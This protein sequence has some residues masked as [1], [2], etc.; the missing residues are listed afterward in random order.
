MDTAQ[1]IVFVSN[2]PLLFLALAAVVGWLL[3]GEISRRTRG[4][5][6]ISP[7]EATSLINHEGAFLLDIREDNEYRG[8]HIVNS[9][10]IPQKQIQDRAKELDKHKGRPVITY[11][12]TGQRSAQVGKVLQ[13]HGF[14][15]VYNLSGGITA[16][17]NANL[18]T[19]RN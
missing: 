19:S 15:S 9:V 8:G 1:F 18:P 14:E 17:Q 16:W 7:L 3:V 12:R 2:H 5:K 4:F 13:Q 11:C 10:H 6:D